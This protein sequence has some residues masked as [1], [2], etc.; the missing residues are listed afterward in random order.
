MNAWIVQYSVIRSMWTVDT[1][2]RVFLMLSS[3]TALVRGLV[4]CEW[5]SCQ[6][7]PTKPDTWQAAPTPT[8]PWRVVFV[9]LPTLN[10]VMLSHLGQSTCITVGTCRTRRCRF[11]ALAQNCFITLHEEGTGWLFFVQ[12]WVGVGMACRTDSACK[13]VHRWWTVHNL[14]ITCHCESKTTHFGQTYS[15]SIRW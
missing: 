11:L 6:R 14:C 5:I 12:G 4:H 15:F 1:S 10:F 3:F 2:N 7:S 9:L 8:H 13:N